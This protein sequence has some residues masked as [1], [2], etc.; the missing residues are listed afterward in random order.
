VTQLA[1]ACAMLEIPVD[2]VT[3][4]YSDDALLLTWLATVADR[5][6]QENRNQAAEA[7]RRAR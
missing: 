6:S 3:L 5:V 7:K 2:P 1:V 4:Y